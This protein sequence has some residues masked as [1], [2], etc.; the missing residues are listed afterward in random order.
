MII[1]DG[2]DGEGLPELPIHLPIEL[3]GLT[4]DDVR[5]LGLPLRLELLQADG[6]ELHEQADVVRQLDTV[7]LH[8][9]CDAHLEWRLCEVLV[10][11][12]DLLEHLLVQC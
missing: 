4:P 7:G 11:Q 3:G 6:R 8:T 5:Q 10:L 9:S 2:Q 12:Q 1:Q